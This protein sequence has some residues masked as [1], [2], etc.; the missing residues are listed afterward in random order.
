MR[1]CRTLPVLHYDRELQTNDSC[2]KKFQS[3][4]WWA[5]RYQQVKQSR[6]ALSER[7]ANMFRTVVAWDRLSVPL[8]AGLI[9]SKAQDQK[10]KRRGGGERE[11]VT[12][13]VEACFAFLL[14]RPRVEEVMVRT[15]PQRQSPK[16]ERQGESLVIKLWEISPNG[17][18]G[19]DHNGAGGTA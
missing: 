15:S 19:V 2:V 13:C 3:Q 9:R 4:E 17:S 1:R 8:R 11:G 14:F 5:K 7:R 18:Q 10:M 6:G 16:Q 12:R